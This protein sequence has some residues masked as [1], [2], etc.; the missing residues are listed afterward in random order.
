M[1]SKIYCKVN[2]GVHNFYLAHEGEEHFLFSQHFHRSVKAYYTNGVTVNEAL[3]N[4]RAGENRALR[5]T[6]EKLPAYIK[7]IEK[8]QGIAVLEKTARSSAKGRWN[9]K[10]RTCGE[11]WDDIA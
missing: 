5:K 7:Y 6:M 10:E 8:E 4:P 9:K 2:N 11:A 1:K 3:N